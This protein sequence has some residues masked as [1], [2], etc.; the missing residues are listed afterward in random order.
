MKKMV[1]DSY[2]IHSEGMV[3][4]ACPS[5]APPAWLQPGYSEGRLE[6]IFKW[7]DERV[8]IKKFEE[9]LKQWF[10]FL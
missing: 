6:L 9:W 1:A 10:D 3:L 8:K 7:A 5:S 4:E 2:L